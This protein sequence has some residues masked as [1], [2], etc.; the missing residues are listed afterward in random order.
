MNDTADKI[1]CAIGAAAILACLFSVL[2]IFAAMIR[3]NGWGVMVIAAPV[4]I[5]LFCIL[6][7]IIEELRN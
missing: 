6:A 2:A 7:D 1:I 5:P 3:D 4:C